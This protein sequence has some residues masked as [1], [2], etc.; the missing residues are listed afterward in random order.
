MKERLPTISEIKRATVKTAPY[1]FSRDTLRFFGQTMS[2]FK[3]KRSPKGNIYIY[4]RSV[5]KD[6]EGARL[7]VVIDTYTL[8]RYD[9][10]TQQLRLTKIPH[11]ER[12]CLE[13]VKRY[14]AKH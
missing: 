1:F 14:I 11:P 6:R 12:L 8:R 7:R 13:D 4:A 2:S 3:V 5:Q 9:P 10:E